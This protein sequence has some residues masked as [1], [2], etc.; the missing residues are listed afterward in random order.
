MGFLSRFPKTL[1]RHRN[2]SSAFLSSKEKSRT[3]LS[4]IKSETDPERIIDL[5][6]GAFLTP[7]SH[8]DRIAFSVAISKLT[9]SNYYPGIRSFIQELLRDRPDLKN[10]RFVSH[11]IVL[12]GQAGMINDAVETFEKMDQLGVH[13]TVK[14]LNALLF[15]CILAKKYDEVYRIFV[16]LSGR[17]DIRPDLDTYNWVIRAFTEMGSSS[18]GYLIVEEMASNWCKPNSTTFGTLIDGFYK[19]E[20]LEDVGKV[21][22][23]MEDHGVKPGLGT[24]NIRIQSLCKLGKSFEAMA[25]LDGMLSRG[26]KPNSVTYSHLIHGFCK[27]GNLVEAKKLFK[28]MESR[29]CKPEGNCYYTLIYFLC[30]GG[31]YETALCICKESMERNFVPNFTTMKSLVHGLVS[32]SKVDEARELIE[33]VKLR[34]PKAAHLWNEVEQ[35]LPAEGRELAYR[36]SESEVP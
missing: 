5:C 25:L 7:D 30:Q 31:D 3:V 16:D 33:R 6:R 1:I 20:K 10:E 14:S 24:Y 13:R 27:Q 36:A 11:S 12:F 2:F 28:T 9:E 29:G 21:L 15:A 17:Y 23:M 19:E 4:L 26:M 35:G 8:L 18:S 32:I 34:F 22:N